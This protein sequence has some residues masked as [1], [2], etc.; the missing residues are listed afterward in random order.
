MIINILYLLISNKK[1]ILYVS[2]TSNLDSSDL[3]IFNQ[4]WKN[5]EHV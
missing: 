2:Y 3:I 1:D 4:G 5:E